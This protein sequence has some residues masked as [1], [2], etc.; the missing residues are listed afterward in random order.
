MMTSEPLSLRDSK[1]ALA[2]SYPSV[3]MSEIWKPGG[4]ESKEPVMVSL[5][6]FGFAERMIH[7]PNERLG[8]G[9]LRTRFPP[10]VMEAVGAVRAVAV[11]SSVIVISKELSSRKAREVN[12]LPIES[13]PL[14]RPVRKSRSP[15][16]MKP[17]A[18]TKIP[19]AVVEGASPRRRRFFASDRKSVV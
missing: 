12:V 17:L 10:R 1:T 19:V 18:P 15:G 2:V 11:V 16:A 8:V 4:I 14:R 9:S 3:E 13:V 5:S 7:S 6:G